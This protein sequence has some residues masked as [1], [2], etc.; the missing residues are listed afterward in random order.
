MGFSGCVISAVALSH[1]LRARWYFWN[2]CDYFIYFCRAFCTFWCVS[3]AFGCGRFYDS[4]GACTAWANCGRT[5]KD[6]GFCQ[7]Y[8]R[9]NFGECRGEYGGVGIAHHSDDETHGIFA[10]IFRCGRG[11]GIHGWSTHAA[12]YGRGRVY[13]ESVDANPLFD[14]CHCVLHS[15]AYLFFKCYLFC[16]FS[17]AKMGDC[18]LIHLRTPKYPRYGPRRLAFCDSYCRTRG[19]TDLRFY[20]YIC[21]GNGNR[22][23]CCCELVE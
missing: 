18:A 13:Y 6:G 16:A 2:D 4:S 3:P 19:D 15:R 12:D 5:G 21:S 7:R 20:T 9:F 1:V 23:Y 22:E 10:Y 8:A 14:H 17:R 11:G